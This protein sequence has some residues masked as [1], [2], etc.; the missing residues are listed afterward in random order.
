MNDKLRRCPDCESFP[1]PDGEN[2][3]ND[4]AVNR[5]EFLRVVGATAAITAGLPT[6]ARAAETSAAKPTARPKR[7]SKPCSMP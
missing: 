5:R 4:H 3:L 6:L 2:A 1:I 7:S